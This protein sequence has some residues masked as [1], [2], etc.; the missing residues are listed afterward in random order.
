MRSGKI[1]IIFA[2]YVFSPEISLRFI[3][4]H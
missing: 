3:D 1:G 4:E 2:L